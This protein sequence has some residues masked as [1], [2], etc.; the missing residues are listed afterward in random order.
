MNCA[1][2]AP[3]A[4]CNCWALSSSLRFFAALSSASAQT[5]C[6]SNIVRAWLCVRTKFCAICEVVFSGHQ[7][8]VVVLAC[9]HKSLSHRG[10]FLQ[11]HL[12]VVVAARGPCG[13]A[14]LARS[15]HIA[16]VVLVGPQGNMIIRSCF[17]CCYDAMTLLRRR[18]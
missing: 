9:K 8:S 5:L 2:G 10:A 14:C 4:A 17:P 1:D 18:C 15:W 3:S 6:V 7:D 11:A 13:V 12:Q 16:A